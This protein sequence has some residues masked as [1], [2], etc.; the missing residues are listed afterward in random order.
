[1]SAG[2]R[3]PTSVHVRRRDKPKGHQLYVTV[4]VRLTMCHGA[5][6]RR[7]GENN[8]VTFYEN[9]KFD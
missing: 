8:W 4:L 3:L 7:L 2:S 6:S 5:A 9:K 1:M